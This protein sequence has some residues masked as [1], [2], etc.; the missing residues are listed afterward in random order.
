MEASLFSVNL[1]MR[2]NEYRRDKTKAQSTQLKLTELTM[3]SLRSTDQDLIV[4]NQVGNNCA[5]TAD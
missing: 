3:C 5:N 4:F 1:L 2:P